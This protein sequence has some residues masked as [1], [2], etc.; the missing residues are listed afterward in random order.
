MPVTVPGPRRNSEWAQPGGNPAK[1]M[2]HVALGDAATRVWSVSIG[3]GNS[4]RTRLVSEPVVGDGRVYTIDTLARVRAFNVETGAMVWEHQVR[5]ENSPSET[6]FGGGVT[7]DGGRVYATNGS[8]DAAA[9]DAATGNQ[10]WMVKPGGPLRGAPTVAGDTVY[11][12]SQD[13]QLY[14]LNAAE[15]R[16]PL[17]RLGLVRARRRVRQRRA[18]FRP[19]HRGRGLLLGRAHRLSLRERPGRLAGRAGAHRHLAPSSERFPTST[20]IR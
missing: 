1:S 17:D 2:V 20:P 7:F 15:R 4:S 13:S 14:A 10:V 19:E 8:G 16:D 11:A 3:A 6:L 5:G 18:R 12:L 9:L